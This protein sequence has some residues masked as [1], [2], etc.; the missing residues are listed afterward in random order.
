M[1]CVRCVLTAVACAAA[2]T[3]PCAAD[4][5]A[6]PLPPLLIS[7][8]SASSFDVSFATAGDASATLRYAAALAEPVDGAD[9]ASS[10]SSSLST[11]LPL[12][13]GTAHAAPGAAAAVTLSLSGL[14]RGASVALSFSLTPDGGAGGNVP[15]V[16]HTAWVVLPRADDGAEDDVCWTCVL[17]TL[18]LY[19]AA[20]QSPHARLSAPPP[21]QLGDAFFAALATASPAAPGCICWRC[22]GVGGACAPADDCATEAQTMQQ[23]SAPPS[24]DAPVAAPP[25][26]PSPPSPPLPH[27]PP[28]PPPSPPAP[29]PPPPVPPPPWFLEYWPELAV[30]QPPPPPRIAALSGPP[31][32]SARPVPPPPWWMGSRGSRPPPP[33]PR[34]T[35]QAPPGDAGNATAAPP[36]WEQLVNE[37]VS[38][39]PP[40]LPPPG[41]SAE[42]SAAFAEGESI[43]SY[44]QQW[45]SSAPALA[46]PT[47]GGGSSPAAVLASVL[48]DALSRTA[49]KQPSAAAAAAAALGAAWFA[50][51]WSLWTSPVYGPYIIELWAQA[52]SAIWP[53]APGAG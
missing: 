24:P 32:P 41:T 10:W 35:A 19:A 30:L 26:P 23:Q 47:A 21:A 2:L 46:A 7:A 9:D 29:P 49:D 11:S 12:E 43:A 13:C 37:R 4:A 20:W 8:A 14:P 51:A 42:V 48:A 22:D 44:V 40:P 28:R 6:S 3:R 36:W 33:P 53:G 52:E 45:L 17:A 1:R 27:P 16:Q 38:A 50:S 5:L 15:A 34:S 18:S 25:L 39:S 31:T